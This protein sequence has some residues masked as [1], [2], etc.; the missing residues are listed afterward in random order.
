MHSLWCSTV[1]CL[2]VGGGG[3]DWTRLVAPPVR[4]R[5]RRPCHGPCRS[6]YCCSSCCCQ[7]D[8]TESPRH[9]CVRAFHSLVHTNEQT[10]HVDRSIDQ[11]RSPPPPKSIYQI[12]HPRLIYSPGRRPGS[13]STYASAPM[14]LCP[15]P[16]PPSASSSSA[17]AATALPPARPLLVLLLLP[18]RALADG[19][20]DDNDNA[21]AGAPAPAGAAAAADALPSSCCRCWWQRGR[22]PPPLSGPTHIWAYLCWC[23]CRGQRV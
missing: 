19:D 16:P 20:G 4:P 11:D 13:P 6:C 12:H 2:T 9:Q 21:A 15:P 5:P 7:M 17:H 8:W 14:L 22:R 1:L 10:I 3:A 18:P 23:A